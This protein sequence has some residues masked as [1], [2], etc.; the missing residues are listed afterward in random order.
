MKVELQWGRT[1]GQFVV[2]FINRQ[3]IAA[4]VKTDTT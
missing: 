4:A 2:V 1:T 3:T